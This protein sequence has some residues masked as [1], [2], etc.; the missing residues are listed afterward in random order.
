MQSK[1]KMCRG[2]RLPTGEKLAEYY[3]RPSYL[4]LGGVPSKSL[5]QLSEGLFE[6]V[7]ELLPEELL[8]QVRNQS[9]I[10]QIMR[11]REYMRA[12]RPLTHLDIVSSL[13]H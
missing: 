8:K 12:L 1:Y 9:I 5:F 3:L 2:R 11:F 7:A 13:E 6:T 10:S 4:I